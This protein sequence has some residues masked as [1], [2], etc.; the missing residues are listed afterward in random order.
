MQDVSYL[1]PQYCKEKSVVADRLVLLVFA[2]LSDGDE[3]QL[4]WSMT[5]C[6]KMTCLP[7]DRLKKEAG[8]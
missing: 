4:A 2:A 8:T 7:P 6:G 5:V 1:S 3:P